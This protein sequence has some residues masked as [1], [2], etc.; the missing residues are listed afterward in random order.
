MI[1]GALERRPLLAYLLRRS[2]APKQLAM[3]GTVVVA[4]VAGVWYLKTIF[5]GVP[6]GV[7]FYLFAMWGIGEFLWSWMAA[8]HVYSAVLQDRRRGLLR[9]L[10]ATPIGARD[11]VVAYSGSTALVILPG[12]F[13]SAAAPAFVSWAPGIADR[14][15]ESAP[16]MHLFLNVGV[17]ALAAISFA[18]TGWMAAM[19]CCIGAFSPRAN[20]VTWM[21]S[22]LRIGLLLGAMGLLLMMVGAAFSRALGTDRGET[23]AAPLLYGCVLL[24]WPL[25]C[26][27]FGLSVAWRE[28]PRNAEGEHLD[29]AQ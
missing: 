21:G 27:A 17:P 26:K 15:R 19:F 10:R 29:A 25:L 8:D 2:F 18:A 9:D 16:A 12:A 11:L 3:L 23:L 14:L 6:R 7:A 13:L 1:A 28:A 4:Y 22:L 5:T 24:V 20:P